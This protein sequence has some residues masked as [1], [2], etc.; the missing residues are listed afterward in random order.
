[1]P[2]SIRSAVKPRPNRGTAILAVT[3]H[4]LE[5]RATRGFAGRDE[6]SEKHYGAREPASAMDRPPCFPQIAARPRSITDFK[7]A[8]SAGLGLTN[9][10]RAGP[11]ALPMILTPALISEIA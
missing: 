9:G 4:G 6:L 7:S 8:S 10:G 11:T 3:F 5:A 2:G 1:M